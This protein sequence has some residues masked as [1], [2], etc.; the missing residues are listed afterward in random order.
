[1]M[2]ITPRQMTR[3]MT[4]ITTRRRATTCVARVR[5]RDF[6][7]ETPTLAFIWA[8]FR[9]PNGRSDGL[10]TWTSCPLA[11]NAPPRRRGGCR[12]PRESAVVHRWLPA[13]AP[14]YYYYT[15]ADDST[16]GYDDSAYAYG[17]D[18]AYGHAQCTKSN[19]VVIVVSIAAFIAAI[20]CI[21]A[22]SSSMAGSSSLLPRFL[23]RD[24]ILAVASSRFQLRRKVPGFDPCFPLLNRRLL[25]LLPR[26]RRPTSGDSSYGERR[27]RRHVLLRERDSSFGVDDGD[28]S[29][30]VLVGTGRRLGTETRRE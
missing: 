25:L 9:G 4:P 21:N 14:A 27:R 12:P 23:L 1:M 10:C 29:V 6:F 30:L 2:P 11:I 8:S 24:G 20:P 18:D 13:Q 19:I 5:D 28:D 17:Y 7:F 16:Y 3:A 26:R 22:T 15:A